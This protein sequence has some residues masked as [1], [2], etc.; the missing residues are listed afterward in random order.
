MINPTQIIELAKEIEEGDPIDWSGL[1][2]NRDAVY[3]MLGLFVMERIEGAAGFTL[4]I[5]F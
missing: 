4:T 5:S 3:N 1:P 2:L